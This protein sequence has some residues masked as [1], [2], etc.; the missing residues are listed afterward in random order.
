MYLQ[1]F[2]INL[3]CEVISTFNR[4]ILTIKILKIELLLFFLIQIK[5]LIIKQI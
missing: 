3:F 4:K 1:L 5:Y 2:N